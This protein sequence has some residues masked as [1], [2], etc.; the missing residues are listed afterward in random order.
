MS[1]TA[2]NNMLGSFFD[3]L[4]TEFPDN[5]VIKEASEKPRTRLMMDRF[6]K[7]TSPRVH[8]LSSRNSVFFSEKN[9]FMNEIGLCEL[10]KQDLTPQTR[11][12]IWGHI[13]NL[14]MIGTSIAMLP[15]QM[16]SL[17]ES[18]A[19]KYAKEAMTDGGEMSEAKLMSSIQK[20]MG[21][22]MKNMGGPS[23]PALD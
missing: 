17:V 15:P 3:D 1:V 21:D 18:T 19:E 7:Y 10:W 9:K 14:H 4:L 23:A 13:Q 20:M 5:K 8:F 6:M 11:N 12:A 16:L 2:F 22:L